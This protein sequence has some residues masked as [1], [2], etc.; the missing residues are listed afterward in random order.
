MESY[1]AQIGNIPDFSAWDSGRA[2]LSESTIAMRTMFGGYCQWVL[3]AVRQTARAADQPLGFKSLALRVYL[4]RKSNLLDNGC[5][6]AMLE[7][8][9]S[10]Q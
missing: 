8:T 7:V 5:G 9:D 2:R 1:V 4:G 3:D 10:V 6:R